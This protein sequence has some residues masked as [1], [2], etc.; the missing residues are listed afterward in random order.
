M[1]KIRVLFSLIIA[2]LFLQYHR[3]NIS[4]IIRE[5]YLSVVDMLYFNFSDHKSTHC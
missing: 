3:G 4:D 2:G 5:Q 1:D